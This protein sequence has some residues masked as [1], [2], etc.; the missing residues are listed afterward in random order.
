MIV[1]S[2]AQLADVQATAHGKS[3]TLCISLIARRALD[4]AGTRHWRRGADTQVTAR[5]LLHSI[6]FS[7]S[8][9][10]RC[11]DPSTSITA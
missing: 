11:A 8:I 10:Q 4:R 3:V 1:G 9:S 7:A 5:V 6:G 2:V